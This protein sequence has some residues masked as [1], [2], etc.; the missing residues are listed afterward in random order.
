MG[1]RWRVII[2]SGIGL[3]SATSSAPAL[4]N[5]VDAWRAAT[6]VDVTKACLTQAYLD[7]GHAPTI[8]PTRDGW[9]FYFPSPFWTLI[10]KPGPDGSTI[11]AHKGMLSSGV[12]RLTKGRDR[13]CGIERLSPHR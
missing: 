1:L 7:Q 6:P 5:E 12:L 3:A 10:L 13:D 2:G 11:L 9:Q 8:N 4:A